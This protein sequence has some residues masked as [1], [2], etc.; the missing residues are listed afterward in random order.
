M[1][2]N[3]II[4]FILK[5]IIVII[6]VALRGNVWVVDWWGSSESWCGWRVVNR[7]PTPLSLSLSLLTTQPVFVFSKS[8]KR[9]PSLF[10]YVSISRSLQILHCIFTPSCRS[11]LLM[12]FI[13]VIWGHNSLSP[14]SLYS[15]LFLFFFFLL[16]GFL[17]FLRNF[18]MF[19]L[20]GLHYA[21][22]MCSPATVS[23]CSYKPYT[24]IPY[25]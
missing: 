8:A 23:C 5:I 18:W 10:I 4:F 12:P 11:T 2:R 17:Y 3:N 25:F 9:N 20:K 6:Y 13:S 15:I 21:L 7:Y 19:Q 16:C 24:K 14:F 1:Y 22:I